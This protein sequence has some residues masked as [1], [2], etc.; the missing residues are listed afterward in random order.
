MGGLIKSSNSL[1]DNLFGKGAG[2]TMNDIFDPMGMFGGKASREYE[3]DLL[4]QEELQKQ[5]DSMAP[6]DAKYATTTASGIQI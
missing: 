4:K 6:S 2:G 3:D 1:S 5:Y